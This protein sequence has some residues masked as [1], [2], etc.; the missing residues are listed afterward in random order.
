MILAAGRGTRMQPLSLLRAKPAMPVRG[1]PVIA[2]LLALLE[3]CGASEV[4]VNLFHLPDTVR[5]AVEHLDI[6]RPLFNDHNAMKALVEQGTVLEMV[7]QKVGA[8]ESS[9]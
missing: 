8:L 2:H 4:I 5:T 3:H 7:E 6:D 9:W 1:V